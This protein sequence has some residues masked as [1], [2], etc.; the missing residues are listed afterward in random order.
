MSPE[1]EQEGWYTDPFGR[2]EARWLSDGVPTKLVRDRGVESYDDPPDTPPT[3]AWK[4]IEA[5]PGALTA[6]DTLRADDVER[7]MTHPDRKD[8][9]SQ[10]L[11]TA[12]HPWLLTPR[13]ARR[14]PLDYVPAPPV[15]VSTLRR[16]ALVAG[17]V[18]S[19]AVLATAT[20]LWV[21]QAI[22]MAT[23]PPPDWG[24][25]LVA[26][27][28]ALA[29]FVVLVLIWHGD[30]RFKVQ[31]ARRILRAEVIAVMLGLFSLLLFSFAA[32]AF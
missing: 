10:A 27:V 16:V 17:G 7:E 20:Y 32:G 11:T 18:V 31:L 3:Q 28:A 24:G 5:P 29:P 2:H 21:V 12:A 14:S 19:G 26:S 13:T 23:P 30:C 8:Y 6:V 4:P 15:P 22:G 1:P 9:A 25:V